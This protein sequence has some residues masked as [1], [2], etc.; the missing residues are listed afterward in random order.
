[1]AFTISTLAVTNVL[2]ILFSLALIILSIFTIH[3]TNKATDHDFSTVWDEYYMAPYQS[4]VTHRLE[5]DFVNENLVLASTGMT[6]AAGVAG[7]VGYFVTHVRTSLSRQD[8]RKANAYPD[9]QT[10]PLQNH[11]N[12]HPPS[13]RIP[14][15]PPLHHHNFNAPHA[16]QELDVSMALRHGGWCEFSL[17]ARIGCLSCCWVAQEWM[18]QFYADRIM[19]RVASCEDDVDSVDGG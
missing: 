7:I 3:I 1:M 5:Y 2:T 17:H 18:G 13:S 15:L 6:L 16:H 4:P 10:N 8:T 19:R 14:L 11:P 9:Q 12:Q